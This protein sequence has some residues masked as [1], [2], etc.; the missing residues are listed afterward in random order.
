[1]T[2]YSFDPFPVTGVSPLWQTVI[3]TSASFDFLTLTLLQ[4]PGD[5]TLTI[6]GTGLL[7]LAGYD[8]TVGNYTFT[9]NQA[10]G[11]FSFSSSQAATGVPDGGATIA[12]LG[13]AL[14]GVEGL[15]RRMAVSA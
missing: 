13:I 8:N 1:M 5:D 10:G 3:G 15:R 7:H 2:P 9:A 6:K 12:L 4:Q 11:T 14:V